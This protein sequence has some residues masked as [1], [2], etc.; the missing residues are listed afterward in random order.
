MAAT[1]VLAA[2]LLVGAGGAGSQVP[3]VGRLVIS[4]DPPGAVVTING[5]AMEQHTNATFT[6]S[7]GVYRVSVTSADGSL[8][9]PEQN[10]PVS[11]GQTVAYTCAAG[12]WRQ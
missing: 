6:V 10:M 2:A 1:R 5:T 9:C 11:A 4:S 3:P 7:A 8:R 12:G